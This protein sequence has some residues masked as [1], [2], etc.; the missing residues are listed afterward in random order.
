MGEVGGGSCERAKA[1]RRE[2]SEH[3]WLRLCL[4]VKVKVRFKKQ[5]AKVWAFLQQTSKEMGVDSSDRVPEN[6][7]LLFVALLS[8]S[9]VRNSS[10]GGLRGA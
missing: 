5:E 8:S 1:E 4:S 7:C 9:R 2:R 6:S 3:M 10:P